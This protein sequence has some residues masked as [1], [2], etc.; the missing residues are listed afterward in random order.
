M[1]AAGTEELR[2]GLE[3]GKLSPFKPVE[4]AVAQLIHLLGEDVTD[5]TLLKHAMTRR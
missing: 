1:M 3:A 5:W 4:R 2:R